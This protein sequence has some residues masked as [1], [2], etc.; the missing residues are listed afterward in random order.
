MQAS[1]TAYPRFKSRLSQTE[2]EQFYTPSD[3]ELMFGNST[4]RLTATRLGF[5]LLLKT[6][7]RLGYFVTSKQ[8]PNSI[9]EHI[10]V[11]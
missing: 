5:V 2:L 8:V 9:I 7:Q 4:T 3:T 11:L 6:Y 1:D 10:G